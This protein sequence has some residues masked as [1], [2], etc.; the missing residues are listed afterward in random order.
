MFKRKRKYTCSELELYRRS[1]LTQIGKPGLIKH[2]GK[3]DPREDLFLASSA[4]LHS[5]SIY[6]FSLMRGARSLYRR[7]VPWDL[8][9]QPVFSLSRIFNPQLLG[10]MEALLSSRHLTGTNKSWCKDMQAVICPSTELHLTV[11]PRHGEAWGIPKTFSSW[12]RQRLCPRKTDP[13]NK[14]SF[15]AVLLW[16]QVDCFLDRLTTQEGDCGVGPLSLTTAL[17][18]SWGLRVIKTCRAPGSQ[19][20]AH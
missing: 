14:G 11:L 9:L 15:Q 19:T 8:E 5:T 18:T 3:I 10:A 12:H 1:A 7:R 20:P 2:L 6:Q 13:G 4:M 17:V 16:G